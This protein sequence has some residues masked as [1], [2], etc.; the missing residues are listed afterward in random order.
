MRNLKFDKLSQKF[1]RG[2][3]SIPIMCFHVNIISVKSFKKK[4]RKRRKQNEGSIL[5]MLILKI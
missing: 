3:M 4:G 2:L 1:V 5:V